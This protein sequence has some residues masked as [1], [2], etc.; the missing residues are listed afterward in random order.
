[1]LIQQSCQQKSAQFRN[2]VKNKFNQGNKLSCPYRPTT[3]PHLRAMLDRIDASQRDFDKPFNVSKSIT[4]KYRWYESLP[5]TTQDLY[6]LYVWYQKRC[7]IVTI[8]HKTAARKLGV[9]RDTVK[10]ASAYLRSVGLLKSLEI[11]DRASFYRVFDLFE[12]YYEK[13]SSNYLWL[14]HDKEAKTPQTNKNLK[15]IIYKSGLS[16]TKLS[17]YQRRE[18]KKEEECQENCF[19][20]LAILTIGRVCSALVSFMRKGTIWYSENED[21]EFVPKRN[22]IRFIQD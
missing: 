19:T 4:D 17:F 13:I 2:E 15:G 22:L 11:R 12:H 16:P 10:K 9:H 7:K 3:N 21:P 18:E 14:D 5:R 8:S 6:D 20:G 1:M